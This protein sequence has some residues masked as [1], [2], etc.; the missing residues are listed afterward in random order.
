[1]IAEFRKADDEEQE[2]VAMPE[3]PL[4]PMARVYVRNGEDESA[5][6]SGEDETTI[7]GSSKPWNFSPV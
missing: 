6:Q 1:L 7:K 4:I 3:V 5:T 2:N